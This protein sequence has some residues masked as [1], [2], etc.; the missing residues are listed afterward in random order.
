MYT[1][2]NK[3]EK[4][5]ETLQKL[6]N[7]GWSFVRLAELYGVTRQRIKQVFQRYNLQHVG[8]SKKKIDAELLWK[9]K[10][11][12]KE[13]TGLYQAQ[14]EKFRNKK[15]QAISKGIEFSVE[16]G[17]LIWPDFCP[18]LGIK[19]NYFAEKV[20]ENSCSFDRVN[21]AKGYTAGNVMVIS[22]RANRIKNDGSAEEH[23]MIADWIQSLD[24]SVDTNT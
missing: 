3:W 8:L 24:L 4:E 2:K 23:R 17:E 21:P 14:R 18:I 5:L 11:G 12:N 22:W 1:T 13:D 6:S 20:E 19:I 9:K 10:W 7:D 15:A 16:F